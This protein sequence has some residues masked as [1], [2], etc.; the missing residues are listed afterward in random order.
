VDGGSSGNDL[1]LT[2]ASADVNGLSDNGAV[3][4]V[5]DVNSISS[6][7]DFNLGNSSSFGARWWGG[8]ASDNL[9]RTNNSGL[10]VQLVNV[11]GDSLTN[12]LLLTAAVADINGSSN[13]GGVYF[14]RDVNSISSGSDF[15]LGSS[16][17]WVVRWFGGSASDELVV[18][19]VNIDG[20]SNSNDLLLTSDS[21]DVNGLVSNGAVY[22]VRSIDSISSGS[23]FNLDNS[24]SWAIRWTGGSASDELGSTSSSGLG[25]QLVNVDG[26]SS[27]NDLV[28]TA[29]NADVSGL[30]DNGVVYLFRDSSAP[31]TSSDVNLVWQDFNSSV[32]LT[33][34]DLNVGCNITQYRVDSD[35]SVSFSFGGWQVYSGVVDFNSDG[36]YSIDFNS[37]DVFGNREVTN[38]GYVLID[39][40]D[41]VVSDAQPGSSVGVADVTPELSVAVSDV[42][43]GVAS[44]SVSVVVNGSTTASSGS[45]SNGRCVYTSAALSNGST[46]SAT[47]TVTDNAGN[48]GS[49]S[50]GT[51]T[52][53]F[54]GSAPGS[55]GG[56]SGSGGGS[57]GSGNP[58]ES[59][60]LKVSSVKVD[61]GTVVTIEALCKWE[62][63]CALYADGNLLAELTKS[64]GYQEFSY[65]P[66]SSGIVELYQKGTT[67][68]LI[69]S[70]TIEVNENEQS[71]QE[72]NE[73]LFCTSN[74]CTD[75]NP[76]T[77]DACSEEE[78][79][80]THTNLPDGTTCGNN[81]MC[82]SGQ[83]IA[84][85][86][87]TQNN[88]PTPI[89]ET[90]W[91]IIAGVIIILLAAIALI[92]TQTGLIGKPTGK[93]NRL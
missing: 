65:T 91:T 76:C 44:C 84:Q 22:V 10:G 88:A 11:N 77:S 2:A 75:D 49:A 28:L 55:V 50:T 86:Q 3:Y 87:G 41:P 53:A 83:C 61:A 25:V 45:I 30:V 18:Q 46:I 48:A 57:G 52:V 72:D 32:S 43:S 62:F 9:G 12:D 39:K 6:G 54:V 7:S 29:V 81:Y 71:D 15:N 8:K 60:L 59:S 73:S 21:A 42:T 35:S 56:G 78:N 16:S 85:E 40:T 19:L 68:T 82:T 36:N 64:S 47:F 26:G 34:S 89:D 70:K 4:L 27:S 1:V 33:C 66:S 74:K 79:K 80:C 92:G 5:R 93:R 13:N 31:V 17:S 67:N 63:G 38:T 69:A 58:E 23:D 90:P 51:Y 20:D 14:I 24:S 37:S